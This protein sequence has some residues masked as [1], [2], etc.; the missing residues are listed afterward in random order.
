MSLRCP[1]DEVTG[2]KRL[3]GPD[4]DGNS[5]GQQQEDCTQHKRQ[6]L[7]AGECNCKAIN[8]QL[9]DEMGAL[10]SIQ[11]TV[12]GY[13]IVHSATLYCRTKFVPSRNHEYPLK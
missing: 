8:T 6:C 9:R 4:Q 2:Y 11:T 5:T 12:N 10:L 1:E 3:F 13:A 7:Q